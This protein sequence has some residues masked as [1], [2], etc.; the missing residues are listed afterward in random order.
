MIFEN[1]EQPY[2]L[3]MLTA[4]NVIQKK[5]AW[6][7]VF[8]TTVGVWAMS[9]DRPALS[10]TLPSFSMV[11]SQN[12]N[13]D[14][15]DGMSPGRDII[16]QTWLVLLP[17]QNAPGPNT[18]GPDPKKMKP[19]YKQEPSKQGEAHQSGIRFDRCFDADS[20]LLVHPAQE[21]RG[22]YRMLVGLFGIEVPHLRGTCEQERALATNAVELLQGVLSQAS[23]I[24]VYDHYK[25]GR[26]HMARVVADGQDLSELLI[27]QGLAV[28]YGDGRKDW[29][30][31]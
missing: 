2:E 1:L 12:M 23:Q 3:T 10:A 21:R 26:K 27:N 4:V 18:H 15:N 31:D 14:R 7:T 24:E 13:A 30:T 9:Y 6:G 5:L 8:I 16:S 25:V 20:C 11:E 22:E 28:P 19:F 29:C 17:F